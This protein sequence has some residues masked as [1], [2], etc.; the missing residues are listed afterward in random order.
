M[1]WAE[2]YCL[3]LGGNCFSW[4]KPRLLS[5]I[6]ILKPLS[7]LLLSLFNVCNSF[8]HGFAQE[9]RRLFVADVEAKFGGGSMDDLAGPEVIFEH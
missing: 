8:H 1:A 9:K 7:R 4:D 2:E 3:L 5:S 6:R